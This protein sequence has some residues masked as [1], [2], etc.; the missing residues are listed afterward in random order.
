[1]RDPVLLAELNIDQLLAR[2]TTARGFKPLPAFPSIRRDV[3][4]ILPETASHQTVVDA[5]KQ[6]RA[7]NLEGVQLF[8]VFRG[9]AVP[10]GHKSVAYAFTYRHAE[11]TLTDEEVNAAHQQLVTQLKQGLNAV[12]RD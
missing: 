2:R 11:R 5:V 7:A 4:M 3:A 8:D 10:A 9:Q 12:I 6:A 1:L